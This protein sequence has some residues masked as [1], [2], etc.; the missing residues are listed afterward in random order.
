MSPPH[1]TLSKKSA[2]LH[3]FVTDLDLY[4]VWR[5]LHPVDKDYTFFSIPHH[6]F[7]R[8]DYFLSSRF[9]L[10]R[11]VNCTIGTQSLSDHAPVS[12]TIS[13]PYRDPACRHWRLNPALLSNHRF[14]DYVTTEWEHFIAINKTP[15]INPS[16][17]WESGKAYIRGAIISY[18][19]A[20]KKEALKTQ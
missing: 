3:E 13:P 6:V 18:T 2:K 17:L 20:Q 7:S 15:D 11:I 9:V 16:V 5:I 12:V 10:D 14:V 1:S 19:S 4:D 8:I